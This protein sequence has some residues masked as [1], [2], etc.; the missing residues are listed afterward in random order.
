[1][2]QRIPLKKHKKTSSLVVPGDLPKLKQYNSEV[3]RATNNNTDATPYLDEGAARLRKQPSKL[4][5]TRSLVSN[6]SKQLM[7]LDE[8]PIKLVDSGRTKNEKHDCN[9][10]EM[11]LVG[12]FP[13]RRAYHS[14]FLMEDK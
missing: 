14:G 13:D 8:D 10:F 12:R 7:I 5:K 3:K 4:D 11:R 6:K 9:W 1:M 2:A